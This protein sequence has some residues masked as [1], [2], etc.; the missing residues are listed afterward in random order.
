[1]KAIDRKRVENDA[2]WIISI[3]AFIGAVF[4][5]GILIYASSFTVFNSDDYITASYD[6]VQKNGASVRSGIELI[7]FFRQGW[8]GY[9]STCFLNGI[10][11]PLK[12]NGL[13]SLRHIIVASNLSFFI[14]CFLFILAVIKCEIKDVRFALLFF[15]VFV[16]L[17]ALL[18]F[19]AEV[20][21]WFTCATG[22]V[23]PLAVMLLSLAAFIYA[24]YRKD[25]FA[26]WYFLSYALGIVAMGGALNITGIGCY[27]VLLLCL[28]YQFERHVNQKRLFYNWSCFFIYLLCSIINVSAPGNY[29]RHA[30]VDDSGLHVLKALYWSIEVYIKRLVLLF[31]KKQ[32]IPVILVLIVSGFF[33]SKTKD[34]NNSKLFSRVL[35]LIGLMMAPIVAVYPTILGYSTDSIPMRSIFCMDTVIFGVFIYCFIRMGMAI[36]KIAK[37]IKNPKLLNIDKSWYLVVAVLVIIASIPIAK[38]WNIP[39][40]NVYIQLRM[41][42]Y[43]T[44]Y[45]EYI[46]LYSL[47]ETKDQGADVIINPKDV[48]NAIPYY[49]NVIFN[50]E[51][52]EVMARYYHLNSIQI[53]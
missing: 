2:F 4:I 46:N 3:I 1:M 51:N 30:I 6:V 22:Y 41:S 31:D 52:L 28:Y 25:S 16:Y 29:Q 43:Q 18:D 11:I 26:I 23:I 35:L 49:Y 53:E 19:Y 14:S 45:Q 50:E 39:M 9:Y 10:M 13:V 17:F 38:P 42:T 32:I 33:A 27:I 34:T 36:D 47:L 21:F 8:G 5:C 15:E 7:A 20:F 12:R 37:T 44:T 40:R 24:N 48:P